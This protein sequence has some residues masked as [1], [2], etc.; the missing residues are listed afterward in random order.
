M[1]NNQREKPLL[2]TWTQAAKTDLPQTCKYGSE[3]LRA[4]HRENSTGEKVLTGWLVLST[5]VGSITS[6]CC[7]KRG[8]R[9]VGRA[10]HREVSLSEGY[11]L[12]NKVSG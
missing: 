7:R 12:Q 4:D 1:I 8:R 11:Q 5:Q 10:M 9:K 3:V 6:H 2:S